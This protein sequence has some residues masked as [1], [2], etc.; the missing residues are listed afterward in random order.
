M[1]NHLIII[2]TQLIKKIQLVKIY[3][4]HHYIDQ[5]LLRINRIIVRQIKRIN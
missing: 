1:N 4:S 5:V 3:Q 2:N